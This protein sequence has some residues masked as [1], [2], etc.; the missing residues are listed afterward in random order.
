MQGL[1]RHLPDF[2]SPAALVETAAVKPAAGADFTPLLK[3]APPAPVAGK[4]VP[5]PGVEA[6]LAKPAEPKAKPVDIAQITREAEERGRAAGEAAALEM[7][8][9]KFQEF[10]QQTAARMQEE[11]EA[12]TLEQADRL[13]AALQEAS[14]DL[15]ERLSAAIAPILVPL[16]EASVAQRALEDLR[17]LMVPL[18]EREDRPV[19][20]ISGP[21]DLVEALRQKLGDP[22]ACVF[23]PSDQPDVR[24]VAGETVLETQIRDWVGRLRQTTA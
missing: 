24:V 4:A 19:L 18:L 22:P 15:E 8:E 13:M 6:L 3:P 2:S 5:S 21:A 11:R 16:L 1:A 17:A 7:F 23:E 12:W 14:V 20:K 9:A 10:Q